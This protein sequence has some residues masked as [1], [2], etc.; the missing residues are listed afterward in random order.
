MREGVGGEANCKGGFLTWCT[1]TPSHG[2]TL[3]LG[4]LLRIRTS[5]SSILKT[6]FL[7]STDSF[8]TFAVAKR[9]F[10]YKGQNLP[11]VIE[12]SDRVSH[13]LSSNILWILLK[14]VLGYDRAV[15]QRHRN[16]NNI[17]ASKILNRLA[18]CNSTFG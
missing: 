14:E 11:I 1:S 16:Y 3:Y 8:F 17:N 15:I 9:H 13:E 6:N 10:Y 12:T 2:N 18:G 5:I 7:R 4:K